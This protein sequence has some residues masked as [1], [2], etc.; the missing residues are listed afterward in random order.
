MLA[1]LLILFANNASAQV[2]GIS[3]PQRFFPYQG[4]GAIVRGDTNTIGMAGATVALPNTISAVEANPA[5]LAMTL[6]SVSAQINSYS[7]QQPELNRSGEAVKEY[8]WGLG[9]NL[10]PWGFALSYYSTA[11]EKVGSSEID[12]RQFRMGVG[13]LLGKRL[14]VG[15]NFEVHKADREFN[16]NTYNAGKI[17]WRLGVLYKLKDHWI[18][19]ASYAPALII[20]AGAEDT[21][22]SGFN[23]A[24]E[25]PQIVSFGVGF[26]PNRFF[27][28]GFSV[29]AVGGTERTT[30]LFDQNI[31]YGQRFTLQP[32]VGASYV[33]A[34]YNWIKAEF[35]TGSYLEV[36]R[37]GGQSDRL[38]F[39]FGL[40]VNPWFINTGVGS[41]LSSHYK[42]FSA[43]LGIDIVRTARFFGIIPKDP[44]PPYQ[45]VLPSMTR[46]SND[47][48]P[49][50]FTQGEKQKIAQ[51]SVKDVQKIIQQIPAR[52]RKGWSP[53]FRKGSRH[54]K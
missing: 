28:A 40:E 42:N 7:V 16:G 21:P 17:G 27:K 31:P 49:S 33:L 10:P 48:L 19:G 22:S 2:P 32:R 23:Q 47:G 1:L 15:F 39:T 18:L 35:A 43:S 6:P 25:E 24:I 12:I 41:D 29:L 50:G 34:E 11:S 45:G 36:S 8:Q 3:Y 44:V 38:H 5:G 4:W 52:L 14:A 37:I 9:A 46:I 13:R 30:L 26:L 51:P 54:H 20:D 53:A